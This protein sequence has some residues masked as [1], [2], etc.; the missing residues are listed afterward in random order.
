MI[1][2][3]IS[4]QPNFAFPSRL[5]L[6]PIRPHQHLSS[7]T[8]SSI[9]NYTINYYQLHK[10]TIIN[11]TARHC[12]HRH[13]LPNTTPI[14]HSIVQPPT[15]LHPVSATSL[16]TNLHLHR[17]F[18]T[19]C[20]PSSTVIS[21]FDRD[22]ASVEDA[23]RRSNHI[24]DGSCVLAV[25]RSPKAPNGSGLLYD[26]GLCTQTRHMRYRSLPPCNVGALDPIVATIPISPVRRLM[27]V[28]E[29]KRPQSSSRSGSD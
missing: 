29:R 21:S 1:Y 22:V 20:L 11:T 10:S 6:V 3:M 26:F 27:H 16:S 24:I 4:C 25:L 28:A 17:H 2:T 19:F 13:T 9:T 7:I 12:L 8:P 18:N 5:P 14:H 15:A 23:T